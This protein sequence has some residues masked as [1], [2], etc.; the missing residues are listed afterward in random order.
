MDIRTR[1]FLGNLKRWQRSLATQTNNALRA[2]GNRAADVARRR[3]ASRVI[4]DRV[5]TGR[6]AKSINVEQIGDGKVSVGTNLKYARVQ[7]EGHP[8][9]KSSR[10]R[11]LLAVPATP[12]LKRA[13]IWPRDMKGMLEFVPVK[14][15][16]AL[17]G[18]LV[19]TGK[20]DNAKVSASGRVKAA[21]R[22]RAR[23]RR[24]TGVGVGESV[25]RLMKEKRKA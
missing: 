19:F 4:E 17:R 12:A 8:N 20:K 5:S 23:F 9:L 10:P 22:E 25:R 18:L 14:D 7:N 6:L 2:A 11:G 3:I 1:A 16:G 15:Q 21:R 24:S 13:G